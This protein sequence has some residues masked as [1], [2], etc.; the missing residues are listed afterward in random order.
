MSDRTALL[1]CCSAEEAQKVRREAEHE[2]RTMAG[3]VLN[4]LLR[5]LTLEE[6]LAAR[7]SDFQRLNRVLARTP[8]RSPGVRTAILVRCTVDEANRIRAAARRRDTTI[9][10]FVLHCLHRSWDISLGK[11]TPP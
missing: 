5:A 1:I 7:L 9:S 8:V 10:G 4:I 3:Y 2:R 11:L 6:R